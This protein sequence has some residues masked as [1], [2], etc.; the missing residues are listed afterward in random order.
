[1]VHGDARYETSWTLIRNAAGGDGDARARFAET[2]QALVRAY[3]NERWRGSALQREVDD[4]VQDVFLECF[5]QATPLARAVPERNGG[6][7]AF[8]VGVVRH[9][10]QRLERKAGR[11]PRLE[12]LDAVGDDVPERA[13]RLSRVLDREWATMLVHEARRLM[14]LRAAGQGAEASRRVELLWLRFGDGLAIREIAARWGV[15]AEWLH[16]EYAR[17]RK[18]FSAALRTA[19]AEHVVR[20]EADLEAECERVLAMLG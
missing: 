6:F 4:C 11:V 18:E 17:A 5:K 12:E 3:L 13:T 20:S 14:E 19:V 7:R 1:M 8:L 2:Y 10:A 15:A 9:V 16:H